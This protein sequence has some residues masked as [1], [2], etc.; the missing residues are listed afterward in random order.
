MREM[1]SFIR[2]QYVVGRYYVPAWWV[3]A[4]LAATF[5]NLVWLGNLAA[6]GCGLLFGS[7]PAWVP[8]SVCAMLYLLS[9]HRGLVRQ[10]LVRTYFPD[11]Q[12]T[13]RKAVRFDVW[14]RPVVALVNWLGV[15]GSLFGRQITWRGISYSISSGGQIRTLWREDEPT[16]PSAGDEK[17]HQKPDTPARKALPYRR[18]G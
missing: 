16:P 15:L 1:Y 18:A 9:V 2:R 6:L 12:Q 17:H 3:F 13:L 8:A 10:D 5:S 14:M 4:F 11:R 7:P